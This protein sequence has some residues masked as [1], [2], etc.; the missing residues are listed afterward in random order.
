MK[1]QL[2]ESLEVYTPQE[3][4]NLDKY[5]PLCNKVIEVTFFNTG[6]RTI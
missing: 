4:E 3:I 2:D 5:L 1:D 6:R